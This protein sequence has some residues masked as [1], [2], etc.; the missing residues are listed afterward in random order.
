M[1]GG[2]EIDGMTVGQIERARKAS[3]RIRKAGKA[4]QDAWAFTQGTHAPD[5]V[6]WAQDATRL[7]ISG[8]RAQL[9][10]LERLLPP[11]PETRAQ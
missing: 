2:G 3:K 7:M 1:T 6:R 8:V 4:S 9:D 10:L 11:E 5:T